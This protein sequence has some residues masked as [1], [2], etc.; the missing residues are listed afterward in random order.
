[1]VG[2][3]CICMVS[4]RGELVGT[5]CT[6]VTKAQKGGKG[7]FWL[8]HR[9]RAGAKVKISGV[10]KGASTEWAPADGGL[11]IRVNDASGRPLDH[12]FVLCIEAP[13]VPELIPYYQYV[14]QGLLSMDESADVLQSLPEESPPEE[15]PEETT[16]PIDLPPDTGP[17]EPATPIDDVPPEGDR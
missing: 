8:D 17:P 14:A 3:D 16:E 5:P 12:G 10:P 9:V 2:I 1:M 11:Q 7:V 13:D 6:G 15:S 4:P